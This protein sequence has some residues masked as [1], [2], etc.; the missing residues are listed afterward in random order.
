MQ[1]V[2]KIKACHGVGVVI[3]TFVTYLFSVEHG[4]AILGCICSVFS[5]ICSAYI[6]HSFGTCLHFVNLSLRI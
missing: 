1:E 2:K 4:Y 3:C 5:Y 6:I